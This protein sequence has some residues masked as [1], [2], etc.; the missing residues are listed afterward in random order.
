M[1]GPLGRWAVSVV[2]LAGLVGCASKKYEVPSRTDA[3]RAE[4]VRLA[5]LIEQHERLQRGAKGTCTVR[6]L[7][8][9]SQTSY[10]WA[11][12]SF[13]PSSGSSVPYRVDG[14]TIRAPQDGSGFSSDVKKMFPGPMADA[15]LEHR[16]DLRPQP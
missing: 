11:D 12:C 10:A 15:I 7:G 9:E 1:R 4:E 13:P 16:D 8:M 6:V 14:T 2:V 3:V 5:A